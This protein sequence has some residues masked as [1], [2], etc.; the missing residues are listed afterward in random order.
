[1]SATATF[2]L[3]VVL[4]AI[5]RTGG[6][7]AALEQ[8]ANRVQHSFSRASDS[9]SKIFSLQNAI[10]VAM[11]GYFAKLGMEF[12]KTNMRFNVFLRDADKA[13]IMIAELND[14]A[15]KTI[16]N[17]RETFAAATPLMNHYKDADVMREKLMM[18]SDVAQG[19]GTITLPELAQKFAI[20]RSQQT[21]YSQDIKEM[22]NRGFDMEYFAKALNTTA[23]KVFDFASEGKIKFKDFEKALQ[24]AT[25]EGGAFYQMTEKISTT[26]GGR[27]D[28]AIGEMQQSLTELSIHGLPLIT[29]MVKEL[30][31][32]FAA[33]TSEAVKAHP[34]L[35]KLVASSLLLGAVAV[36]VFNVAKGFWFLGAGMVGA[37][38]KAVQFTNVVATLTKAM[39]TGDIVAYYSNIA[40]ASPAAQAL[41]R[42]LSAVTLQQYAW[43]AAMAA[44]IALGA[45]AV[46]AALTAGVAYYVWQKKR[47]AD[48][49]AYENRLNIE[50]QKRAQE[51]TLEKK[52]ELKEQMEALR[53]MREGSEEFRGAL[54]KLKS[55]YPEYLKNINVE[56]ATMQDLPGIYAKVAKGLDD[57]AM[58]QALADMKKEAFMEMAKAEKDKQIALMS[59]NNFGDKLVNTFGVGNAFG[60]IGWE[61]STLKDIADANERKKNAEFD[62]ENINKMIERHKADTQGSPQQIVIH[63]HLN[64]NEKEIAAATNRVNRVDGRGSYN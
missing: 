25:Q 10:P 30:V 60:N 7:F 23:D 46:I 53:K 51:S 27:F 21:L 24:L 43:N 52:A 45:V 38:T 6:A 33:F 9:F 34:A 61:F 56:K 15:N 20:F 41:A 5:N 19:L 35:S 47:A 37:A 3:S 49:V 4:S 28:A 63:S 18:L 58:A 14:F 26:S 16:Y 64:L 40:K 54:R 29:S 39:V 48:A 12:E 17:S 31:T 42:G 1:M 22:T 57:L 59:E 44:N 62:N 8:N 13:K 2:S 36:P 11:G 55:E 50:A 32:P